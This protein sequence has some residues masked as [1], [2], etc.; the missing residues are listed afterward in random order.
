M[1][2]KEQ[3]R[4]LVRETL[5][6]IDKYSP[7]AEELV[8]GTIAQ[9]SAGGKYIK[10]LGKGPALGICQMEPFTHDDIWDNYL[11]YKSD[12]ADKII[13]VCGI[14]DTK[15]EYLRFN[16]KYSI[17]MCRVHYLRQKGSIPKDLNGLAKYWKETYNTIM[18]KGTEEEF[19]KHYN[20]YVRD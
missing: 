4:V 10:Q 20:K 14:D 19:I 15:A 12:L 18:G 3:L 7:E 9:E 5:Q 17:A 13:D 6:D 1:I 2:N 8:L 11:K 16:L